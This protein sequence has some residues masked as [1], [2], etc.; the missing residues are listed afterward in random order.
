MDYS[1]IFLLSKVCKLL[2]LILLTM[3]LIGCSVNLANFSMVTTREIDWNRIGN[4]QV[5]PQQIS[6]KDMAHIVIIIPTKLNIRIDTAITNAL[7][8][9]PG[10]VAMTN[11]S[12]R[13]DWFYIPYI[14]GQQNIIARGNIIYD[15]GVAQNRDRAYMF[16]TEDGIEFVDVSNCDDMKQVLKEL[17]IN[18]K[19]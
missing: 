12:V 11:V 2:V 6:G 7:N 17:A 3:L 18:N 19:Q 5:S 9:I 13:Q 1:K 4:W 15:S 8:Q 14:Y 16:K 10:A